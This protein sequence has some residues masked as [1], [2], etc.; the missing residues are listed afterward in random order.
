MNPLDPRF[1]QIL[2]IF[3]AG[4]LKSGILK[5]G[6][7]ALREGAEALTSAPALKA[8]QG[9]L[10][11]R[12]GAAQKFAG[13]NKPFIRTTPVEEA[14]RIRQ[15]LPPSA[16]EAVRLPAR[17]PAGQLNMFEAPPAPA[18][19][20]KTTPVQGPISRTAEQ[21]YA[22]DPG[23]YRAINDLARRASAYYG[24]PVSVDDLVASG[25]TDFLRNLESNLPGASALVRSPGGAMRPPVTPGAIT[26]AE[27]GGALT[28]SPGGLLAKFL[29]GAKRGAGAVDEVVDVDVREIA[30]AM[31]GVRQLDLA[32][33]GLAIGAPAGLAA[34]FAAGRMTAPAGEPEA[35]VQTPMGPTSESVDAGGPINDPVS[36]Q[37]RRINAAR[38]IAANMGAGAPMPKPVYRGADGQTV[39]TTRGEDEALTAAKQQ[40]AKPQREL[41]DY[42]KQREAYAGFPAHKAEVI[43]ELTKRGVLD[44]P[45]LVA[46][47]GANPEL[48]Y[49]LLRKATGSNLLPSQQVPQETQKVITAPAGS[50]NANNMIGNTSATAEAAV[51]GTQ[52]ASDLK[53]FTEPQLSDEIRTLNP[54]LIYALQ[55]RNLI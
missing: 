20:F 37:N 41:R 18:P 42:Y 51:V 23:T 48:A 40:Y 2:K 6:Q 34:A 46:W 43:S 39:I 27:Q 22:Q 54:A 31:G 29:G 14:Y 8:V 21:L 28:R 9:E 10:L 3:G 5:P 24:K 38:E 47:A 35:P 55:G 11:T 45:Q 4:L 49:E 30:N 44:S 52:G 1:Q 17:P 50:N 32:K 25:G 15:P 12:T 19:A 33:L 36:A 53:N 7:T 26:A 16:A 13:G